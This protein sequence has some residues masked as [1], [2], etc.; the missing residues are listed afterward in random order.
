MLNTSLSL[1]WTIEATIAIKSFVTRNYGSNR[2]ALICHS[3]E[4][5]NIKQV[6]PYE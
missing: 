5:G 6:L 1:E 3:L 2:I 4:E